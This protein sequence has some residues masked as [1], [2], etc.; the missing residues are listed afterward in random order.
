MGLTEI[1]RRA[2]WGKGDMQFWPVNACWLW[3]GATNKDGYGVFRVGGVLQMAHKVSWGLK[4]G[5]AV[6]AGLVLLHSCDTPPCCRPSH[7]S[8]GS[9]KENVADAIKKGRR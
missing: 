7:L 4:H 8:E 9:Q 5:R 2:F 3:K 6:D 1:E